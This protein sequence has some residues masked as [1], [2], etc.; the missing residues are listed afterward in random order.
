MFGNKKRNILENGI[1]ARAVITQVRDTGVTIND[2]PRVELTLQVQPE[3]AMPFEA[4]KKVT[5]SRVR[6]PSI[7]GTMWVRYDP[8]DPSRVEFDDAKTDEVNAAAVSVAP[9]DA[10]AA[11]GGVQVLDARNIPGLRDQMLKAAADAQATGNTSELQNAVMSALG[12]AMPVAGAVP[13]A[14]DPL[15][16]LKKL[17]ELRVAGALTEAEFATE[18]A[19]IL[20]EG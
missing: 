14:D 12:Q 6:I 2:N 17:N 18:K 10:S 11:L 3:G 9:A 13:E 8:A 15:E 5:V 16:R 7:G 20:G 4:K 1:Q 19:K